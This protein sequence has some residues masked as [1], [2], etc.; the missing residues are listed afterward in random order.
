MWQL[1][2]F[3]TIIKIPK[4]QKG[5]KNGSPSEDVL[6]ERSMLRTSEFFLAWNFQGEDGPQQK[7]QPQTFS[8]PEI[9]SERILE[10]GYFVGELQI[11]STNGVYWWFGAQKGFG[12]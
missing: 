3:W 5:Q 12:F 9:S 1:R 6:I 10:G 11:L 7:T 8:K 4:G 2:M